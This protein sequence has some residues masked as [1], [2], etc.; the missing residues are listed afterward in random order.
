MKDFL[1]KLFIGHRHEWEPVETYNIMKDSGYIGGPT[2]V[3]GKG[4][5]QRCKICGKMSS[6]KD[7]A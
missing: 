7:Y 4:Y 3:I 2:K 6:F 1:Y 5:V